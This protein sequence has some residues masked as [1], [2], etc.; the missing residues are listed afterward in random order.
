MKRFYGIF[1]VIYLLLLLPVFFLRDTVPDDGKWVTGNVATCYG[2]A[3]DDNGICG[4]NELEYNYISGCHVAIPTYC[5]KQADC[6]IEEYAMEDYPEL[7]EGYG[8]VLEVRSPETGKMVR[9]VAADCGNFGKHNKHNHDAALDLPPNTFRALGM[10]PD[11]VPIE[12]RVIGH[13]G[14]WFGTQIELD[15]INLKLYLYAVLVSL[16]M[17][18]IMAWYHTAIRKKKK[19]YK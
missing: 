15:N 8:T 5:V 14:T 3:N 16:G 10:A 11:T 7:A 4:W 1:L 18:G 19:E 6:Y 12:Y 13:I 17:S 2:Y 9:A